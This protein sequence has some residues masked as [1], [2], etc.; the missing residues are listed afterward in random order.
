MTGDT[1]CITVLLLETK[2][3]SLLLTKMLLKWCW[4]HLFFSLKDKKNGKLQ[5]FFNASLHVQMMECQRKSC[6]Q[7][8][9][10][11][12]LEASQRLDNLDKTVMGRMNE[13]E[14]G[15]ASRFCKTAVDSLSLSKMCSDFFFFFSQNKNK[16]QHFCLVNLKRKSWEEEGEKPCFAVM[17]L[18][19]SVIILWHHKYTT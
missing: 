18:S 7:N 1:G 2:L 5:Y 11:P 14:W 4:Y 8:L 12:V 13:W 16:A 3:Y 19:N 9:H 10:Q 15:T 6:K 17:V